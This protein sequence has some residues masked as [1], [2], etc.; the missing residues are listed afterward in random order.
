PHRASD[1]RRGFRATLF[2]EERELSQR[3]PDDVLVGTAG[4]VTHGDLVDEHQ[5]EGVLCGGGV[6]AL[7]ASEA[8]GAFL[9]DVDRVL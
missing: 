7:V 5:D 3:P 8:G 1:L 4:K 9:H 2:R 6:V